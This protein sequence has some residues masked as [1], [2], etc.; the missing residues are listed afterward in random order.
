MQITDEVL[1]FVEGLVELLL[2]NSDMETIAKLD[3]LFEEH[4]ER[5]SRPE[6][7]DHADY[8]RTILDH[9][10]EVVEERQQPE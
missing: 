7:K 8:W 9:F 5:Q 1:D 6:D 4:Y 10:R 2:G 3:K